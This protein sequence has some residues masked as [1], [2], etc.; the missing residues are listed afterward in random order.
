MKKN[1][2]I[3]FGSFFALI[4]LVFVIA[5]YFAVK[6]T[7]SNNELKV[8]TKA[9]ITEINRTRRGDEYYYD[10]FVE[11]EIDGTKYGAE[12]NSYS[13]SYNFIKEFMF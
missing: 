8:D 1:S 12:L 6:G 13:S 11:Y 2:F 5:G 3:L 7:N 9:V 4:G 10:V